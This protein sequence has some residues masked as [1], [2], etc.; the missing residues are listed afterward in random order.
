MLKP[1][2]LQREYELLKMSDA[3]KWTSID[4]LHR[5]WKKNS[6][7]HYELAYSRRSG[8]WIVDSGQ[9]REMGNGGKQTWK[10]VRGREQEDLSPSLPNPAPSPFFLAHFF[11]AFSQLFEGLLQ[12]KYVHSFISNFLWYIFN[13][14]I[15]HFWRFVI[16]QQERIWQY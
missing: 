11:F 16:D 7:A 10:R 4:P 13:L 12:V 9:W 2:Q 1:E 15:E 6:L 14:N 5:H 3:P 8:Q